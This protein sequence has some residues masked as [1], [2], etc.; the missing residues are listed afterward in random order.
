MLTDEKMRK[1]NRGLRNDSDFSQKITNRLRES[2]RFKNAPKKGTFF[3]TNE[4][5]GEIQT[6]NAMTASS[7]TDYYLFL[8]HT[9]DCSIPIINIYS[10]N[11]QDAMKLI[12]NKTKGFKMAKALSEVLQCQVCFANC[13]RKLL[14]HNLK[15]NICC[16]S[17][18]SPSINQSEYALLVIHDFLTRKKTYENHAFEERMNVS[19]IFNLRKDSI[20]F[21]R[22]S[23]L[24]KAH[25][26]QNKPTKKVSNQYKN[27]V[28]LKGYGQNQIMLKLS[29]ITLQRQMGKA[30]KPKLL[31]H[32]GKFLYKEFL[33]E[34][35]STGQ[36]KCTQQCKCTHLHNEWECR[37]QAKLEAEMVLT[38]LVDS[39]QKLLFL[40]DIDNLQTDI[41]K[42]YELWKG[43]WEKEIRL[44]FIE[45][46]RR[47]NIIVIKRLKIA[48]RIIQKFCW[49][50][51]QLKHKEEYR[52]RLKKIYKPAQYSAQKKKF[53][54]NVCKPKAMALPVRVQHK[55]EVRPSTAG[56]SI[57][58]LQQ[59]TS[60]STHQ[61]LDLDPSKCSKNTFKGLPEVV[62]MVSPREPQ[63]PLHRS[64]D[65]AAMQGQGE[66]ME[67]VV[68]LCDVERL[69]AAEEDQ[70][71]KEDDTNNDDHDNSNTSDLW[72]MDQDDDYVSGSDS[73]E[74]VLI[75][76][77]SPPAELPVLTP[78]M[79]FKIERAQN[80]HGEIL[81]DAHRI[82]IT[83]NDI[84]TLSGLNWL[85][86]EIIN[87]YMQMIVA[88]S[89]SSSNFRPVYAFS[90][91]FYSRL[92]AGGYTA[93]QRWT[94]KMDLFSYSLVL[95]PIHLGL[96]WSL[97]A[98]DMDAK[99][100][101][102]YDSMGVNNEAALAGL[103]NYLREEHRIKKQTELDLSE[104]KQVIAENIPHQ[105]NGSDCGMFTCLF[106][107]YLSRSAEFTFSQENIPY[108]R[109]RMVYEI[110]TNKFMHT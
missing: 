47:M 12:L 6:S 21:I 66:M 93:V 48:T 55:M 101:T 87:F 3:I 19:N 37:N 82:K 79:N 70:E 96:H 103:S 45:Q 15:F 52:Q 78:E 71:E 62:C 50:S 61:K 60:S 105:I 11:H 84:K 2:N 81:V 98:L 65:T 76:D 13:D 92:M 69:R 100:I 35:Q 64:S 38:A 77:E 39:E 36:C 72:N 56:A 20:E 29:K 106:A 85:N 24:N 9:T 33:Q 57:W 99:S 46:M 16:P 40:S 91:Y 23:L 32:L 51:V 27:D 8:I 109:K 30:N 43:L 95:V 14:K 75:I 90:T 26:K 41:E 17:D 31:F 49:V 104:W 86:D 83:A 102:Y 74:D 88:R 59:H 10:K 22:K 97:A 110:C 94:G 1:H 73:E 108:F 7:K 28:E 5:D 53:L 54:Q 67:S 4:V 80:S 89:K 68:Q 107:E 58:S 44:A 63:P 18:N 25:I 42:E 34:L